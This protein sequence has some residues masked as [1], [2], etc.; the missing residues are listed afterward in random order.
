MPRDFL[1]KACGLSLRHFKQRGERNDSISICSGGS[2][3]HMIPSHSLW[4]TCQSNT[5]S[6]KSGEYRRVKRIIRKN[7]SRRT[8]IEPHDITLASLSRSHLTHDRSS[9]AKSV[10]L[11]C[12]IGTEKETSI[13]EWIP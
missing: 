9:L 6:R 3:S 5:S 4:S 13:D 11:T 10:M 8:A 1:L 2:T 7:G 12:E